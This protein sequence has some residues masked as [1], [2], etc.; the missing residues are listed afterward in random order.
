MASEAP[1][2]IFDS[3]IGGL[4]VAHAVARVLPAEQLSYFGDTAHMPYGDRSPELVRSWSVRIAQHLLDQGCKAIVIAC[5]SA[6]ATA[7]SAV[8]AKTLIGTARRAY[9]SS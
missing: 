1:I 8:R 4:T 6:S 3:G 9:A 2:G 7:A 5:N